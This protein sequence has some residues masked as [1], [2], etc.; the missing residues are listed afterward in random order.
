MAG[1][2]GGVCARSG[3]AGVSGVAAISSGNLVCA[4][5]SAFVSTFSGDFS[6]DFSLFDSGDFVREERV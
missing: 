1:G 5:D 3:G 4:G 6:G 2:A